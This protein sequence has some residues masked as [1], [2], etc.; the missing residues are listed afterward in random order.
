MEDGRLARPG[1]GDVKFFQRPLASLLTRCFG[2]RTWSLDHALF[3][4][5]QQPVN[6]S[7]Q[8]HQLAWIFLLRGQLAQFHPA[9]FVVPGHNK[10]LLRDRGTTYSTLVNK[11]VT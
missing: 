6:L 1:L 10:N 3:F 7:N 5:L 11:P 9:F 4:R 2:G 8:C